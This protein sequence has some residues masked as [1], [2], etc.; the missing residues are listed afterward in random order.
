MKKNIM[1]ILT[2]FLIIIFL[3]IYFVS[4]N[5]KTEIFF[6]KQNIK[7]EAQLAQTILQQTKGLMNV[8]NL[9]E[10]QGMLFVFLDESRKSFWMK[11]TY[12]PLDLIFISRDKKIVEIKENFEPCQQKN[13]PSYTSQ[14]KAKYVLEVNGG[15]CQKHQIKE[16][17]EVRFEIK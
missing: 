4:K 16:G 10:N 8:K 5:K 9:P 12:I 11:N 6:P 7:I 14:K 15:F 17:D 13:C 3:S 2:I 1:I